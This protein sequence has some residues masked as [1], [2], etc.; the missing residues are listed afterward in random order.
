LPEL[1]QSIRSRKRY[2]EEGEAV[3]GRSAVYC[4]V[5]KT[6]LLVED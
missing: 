6:R 2:D 5:V 1:V 4:K 3:S